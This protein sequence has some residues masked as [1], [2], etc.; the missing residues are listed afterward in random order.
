MK[1]ENFISKLRKSFPDATYKPESLIFEAFLPSCYNLSIVT[2]KDNYDDLK[3]LACEVEFFKPT[4]AHRSFI[5]SPSHI[6][7]SLDTFTTL[8]LLFN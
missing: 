3:T 8:H 7:H 4:Y 6:L 2:L 5:G 1:L